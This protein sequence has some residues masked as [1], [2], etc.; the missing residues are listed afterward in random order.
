MQSTMR[1]KKGQ[2]LLRAGRT[3]DGGDTVS[4]LPPQNNS[5]PVLIAVHRSPGVNS[6]DVLSLLQWPM[7]PPTEELGEH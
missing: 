5:T 3:G 7:W 4:H 6:A 2:G 1:K